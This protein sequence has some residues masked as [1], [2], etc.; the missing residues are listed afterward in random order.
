MFLKVA[1]QPKK[2]RLSILLAVL[3][4]LALFI[5]AFIAKP[6]K[7]QEGVIV[8]HNPVLTYGSRITVSLAGYNP[9]EKI[10]L[11]VTLPDSSVASW[12]YVNA[13]AAGTVV[14]YTNPDYYVGGRPED[15]YKGATAGTPGTWVFTARGSVSG[16][17]LSANFTLQ[18][19]TLV[20]DGIVLNKSVLFLFTGRNW[21]PGEKVT[22]WVT[23][24]NGVGVNFPSLAGHSVSYVWAK[25]DGSLS[26][27]PDD[28]NIL[29]SPNTTP[30]LLRVTAS[31]NKS[32]FLS[33]AEFTA[34]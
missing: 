16:L 19:P 15:Y 27:S 7:A 23:Y 24:G 4:L 30:G 6:A 25:G 34:R 31:G 13:T 12:G 11:W 22:F 5:P 32:G 29:I 17:T 20:A 8:I 33:I 21:F 28:G 2:S 18:A 9:G 26:A 3:V 1:D 14:Q 10:A